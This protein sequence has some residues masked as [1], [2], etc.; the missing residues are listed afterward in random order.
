MITRLPTEEE[1]NVFNTL[2]EQGAVRKFLGKD[3]EQARSLFRENF[4]A[5]QED[6]MWMGPKAFCFYVPAAAVIDYLLGPDSDGDPG[7]VESFCDLVEFRLDDDRAEIASA[8]PILRDAIL[9]IL[10]N[11]YRY[12]GDDGV[13]NGFYGDITERFRALLSRL[14]D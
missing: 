2:D 11:I 13:Y 9:A 10:K 5:Y 12:G 8:F 6:L 14:G 1:I 3:L 4:R 7:A